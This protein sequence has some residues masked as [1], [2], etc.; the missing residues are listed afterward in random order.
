[1][2]KIFVYLNLCKY[3]YPNYMYELN[4]TISTWTYSEFLQI[5]DI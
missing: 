1:M 2:L 4:T 3:M 5:L